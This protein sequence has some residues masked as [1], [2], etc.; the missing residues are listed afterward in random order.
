MADDL[1]RDL[2]T[3]DYGV[4]VMC[5][6]MGREYSME[7]DRHQQGYFTVALLEALN[8]KADTNQDQLVYLTEIDAYISDRV[9]TLT[10]GMQHPVTSKPT[11]IRSFPIS[12]PG[13]SGP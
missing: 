1:I 2:A 7:S 5:S 8:G 6:S 3:D 13:V 12:K 9:K 11:T 10:D 4:I